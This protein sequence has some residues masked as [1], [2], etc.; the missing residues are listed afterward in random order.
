LLAPLANMALSRADVMGWWL[1]ALHLVAAQKTDRSREL[2]WAEV[3]SLLN[4][5]PDLTPRSNTGHAKQTWPALHLH[6]CASAV[7]YSYRMLKQLSHYSSAMSSRSA[8]T[9]SRTHDQEDKRKQLREVLDIL[10]STTELFLDVDDLRECIARLPPDTLHSRLETLRLVTTSSNSSTSARAATVA[11]GNG[12]EIQP[13]KRIKTVPS[14]G[15]AGRVRPL[16]PFD[17]LAAEDESDG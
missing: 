3:A 1:A 14:S 2:P 4:T 10:P 5:K 15:R 16:N 7:L 13:R 8:K 11:D 6:A 9:A 12:N 17:V